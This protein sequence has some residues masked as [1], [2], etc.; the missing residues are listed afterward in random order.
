MGHTSQASARHSGNTEP[1]SRP[2]RTTKGARRITTPKPSNS[3]PWVS[4]TGYRGHPQGE[5]RTWGK[6]EANGVPTVRC[7]SMEPTDSRHPITTHTPVPFTWLQPR[8]MNRDHE[9]RAIGTSETSGQA[10]PAPPDAKELHEGQAKS[11][12]TPSPTRGRASQ[13]AWGEPTTSAACQGPPP[14]GDPFPP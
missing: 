2:P 3:F 13:G 8:Q 9:A 12:G 14:G 1:A 7:T 6:T 4:N 5:N 10:V 11:R